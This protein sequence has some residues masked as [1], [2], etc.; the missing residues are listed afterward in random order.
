MVGMSEAQ[1]AAAGIEYEIGRGL[2]SAN[3]KAKIS[4]FDEGMVKL[5]FRR[6]DRVLLGVH[7]LGEMASELIH[8]GQFVLHERAP[9]D[10]F[11]HATFAVP[12][13]SD[14]YKYAAYDGLMRLDRRIGV[15]STARLD[16]AETGR[17]LSQ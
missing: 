14:A 9:I 1:A 12:T 15:F 8:L 11:I 4:G 7:I 10:R 17:P 6:D 16:V 3:A 5:V 13:R 2:F